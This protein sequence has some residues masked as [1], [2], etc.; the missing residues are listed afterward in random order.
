[1]PTPKPTGSELRAPVA[2]DTSVGAFL[3]QNPQYESDARWLYGSPQYVWQ[4]KA[5]ARING[6][7]DSW[8]MQLENKYAADKV[9]FENAYNS[10]QNQSDML[11]AAGYN[12]N[13]LGSAPNN[14]SA[15]YLPMSSEGPRQTGTPQI[16]PLD[17]LNFAAQASQMALDAY[18]RIAD[19]K[20]KGAQTANMEA[21]AELTRAMTPFKLTKSYFDSLPDYLKWYGF[22]GSDLDYFEPSKG[23]GVT[24]QGPAGDSIGKTM[25]LNARDIQAQH[26]E[27]I[28]LENEFQKLSNSEKEYV[29][30]AIQPMQVELMRAQK[31]LQLNLASESAARTK[32]HG[33]TVGL[34]ITQR[35]IAKLD[36]EL[37]GTAVQIANKYGLKGASQHYFMNWANLGINAAKT[38]L[39]GYSVLSGSGAGAAAAIPAFSDDFSSYSW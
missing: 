3:A 6:A 17:S 29:I 18:G 26:L 20:L 31:K 13:W 12:R 1:M 37:K 8:K 33:E 25:M 36:K 34:V 38:G 15:N 19:V 24:F 5:H 11:A 35:Q 2:P 21:Q 32:I 30:K 28:K 39:Y 9:D 16:T 4:S 7:Y 23:Y 22:S 14:P 27:G 10:Y